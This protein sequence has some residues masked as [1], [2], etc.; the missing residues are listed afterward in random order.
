MKKVDFDKIEQ[1]MLRYCGDSCHDREHIYR[2]LYNALKYPITYVQG[3]PG[4]GK[5]QTIINVALSAMYNNKT[6]LIC[7]SNNKPVDGIV[8][9]LVFSYKNETINFP[10]LRL[11]NFED[12]KKATLRIKQLYNYSYALEPK[13]DLLE[14]IKISTD[15]KNIKFLSF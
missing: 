4:T 12:V 13:D 11:G 10:F 2:V 3:P 8:E 5:T 6:M 1:F 7:S 15:D 14:K 9:K